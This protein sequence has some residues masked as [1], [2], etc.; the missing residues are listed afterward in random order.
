MHERE[1]DRRVD[2]V[3]VRRQQV[4]GHI[5]EGIEVALRARGEKVLRE[6][7]AEELVGQVVVVVE[8]IPVD[9]LA[10]EDGP[11]RAERAGQQEDGG[12][13][14]CYRKTGAT[15]RRACSASRARVLPALA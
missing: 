6:P 11:Q 15:L 14:H 3:H 8:E 7:T 9:V 12:A 2:A 4:E 5:T 10:G 1:C 13:P